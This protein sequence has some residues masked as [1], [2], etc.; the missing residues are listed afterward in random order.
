MSLVSAYTQPVQDLTITREPSPGSAASKRRTTR[1]VFLLDS[2]YPLA[3]SSCHVLDDI[4]E[5]HFGRGVRAVERALIDGKR[6]LVLRFSDDR[7]SRTHGVLARV[8]AEWFLV[9]PTS[10][11]GLVVDGEAVRRAKIA[12]GTIFELG[13]SFFLLRESDAARVPAHLAGDVDA[14]QFHDVPLGL[15]T[16]EPA[17]ACELE[18]VMRLAVSP[19]SMLLLGETGTGKELVARAIHELSHRT[20]ELVAVNCGALAPTLLESEL[21]GHRRGAFSGASE[22]RKGLIRFAH[23][24][25]LLLDEIGELPQPSQAA[26]LRVLQE[27]E[28]LPVGGDRALSVDLRVIAATVCD[29]EAALADRTFRDDLYARLCGHVVTLLPLRQRREDL[30]LLIAALLRKITIRPLRFTS[31]ALWALLRY[32]WPR[33]IRE[34][35]QVL[36]TAN[37]LAAAD[38]IEL[39]HLPA[40]LRRPQARVTEAAKL[41]PRS[42]AVR[43]RL[44]EALTAHRG[45]VWAVAEALGKARPQIYRWADRFAI[46]LAEFRR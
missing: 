7:M 45:N 18:A 42:Q 40:G 6:V 31:S 3:P 28:V 16:F 46:D 41:D 4:D 19:V 32:H 15:L 1:L 12:D 36:T 9:D 39:E 37:A 20:G 14:G 10:K 29:L 33:N 21:F 22:D 27:R 23:Q 35:E 11:N 34:L 43:E 5:V 24:G 26:L 8:G 2:A 13:H 38:V 44:I 30:G 17:F 25:T